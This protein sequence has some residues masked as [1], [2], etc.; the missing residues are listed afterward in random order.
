MSKCA[1]LHLTTFPHTAETTEPQDGG[2]G[3]HLRSHD[4]PHP[5]RLQQCHPGGLCSFSCGCKQCF[6]DH[7]SEEVGRERRLHVSSWEQ[8]TE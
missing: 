6:Q 7:K 4:A 8:G 5:V 2:L 1:L 3:R